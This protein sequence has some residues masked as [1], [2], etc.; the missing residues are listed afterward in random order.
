MDAIYSSRVVRA[1]GCQ[2]QKNR[3]SSGFDPNI[4]RHNAIE[5]EGAAN[6]AVLNKVRYIK[7]KK[8]P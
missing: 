6:E 8:I 4:L 1:F 5:A 7:R 3:N 2:C